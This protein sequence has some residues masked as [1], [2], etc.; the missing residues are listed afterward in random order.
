MRKQK[1]DLLIHTKLPRSQVM[2]F[3][4]CGLEPVITSFYLTR[5]SGGVS[6]KE[7]RDGGTTT[8][9]CPQREG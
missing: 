5:K 8:P 4:F 3:K 1:S 2:L 7:I 6:L 9:Q